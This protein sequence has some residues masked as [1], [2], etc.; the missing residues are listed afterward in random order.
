[1]DDKEEYPSGLLKMGESNIYNPRAKFAMEQAKTGDG[2]LVHI[3]SCFNNK[4]W[5]PYASDIPGLYK[6]V[7]SANK[8]QEDQT[9]SKCT[10]FHVSSHYTSE[11][12]PVN[13]EDLV[14]LPSQVS[15]KSQVLDGN[16]LGSGLTNGVNYHKFESGFDTGN[17]Q[18]G[19]E[20]VPVANGNYRIR[21][22]SF[23]KYWRGGSEWVVADAEDSNNS[24]Y[25]LFSFIKISD[26]VVAI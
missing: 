18:V 19:Y 15:F 9:D 21:S 23:G 4:Y 6:I 5:V 3:R 24:D 8:P 25:T 26:N 7:A 20:L 1:M 17:P 16:Y 10:L 11:G 13:W 22:L 12:N 2:T 14:I